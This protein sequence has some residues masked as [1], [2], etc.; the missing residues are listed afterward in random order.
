MAVGRLLTAGEWL[1]HPE[2]EVKLWVNKVGS[3]SSSVCT[4][5]TGRSQLQGLSVGKSTWNPRL[6][7]RPGTDGEIFFSTER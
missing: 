2:G 5:S 3:S 6:Q 7:G 1:A 4:L